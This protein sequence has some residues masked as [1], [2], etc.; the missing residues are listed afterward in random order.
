MDA[1]QRRSHWGWG[2][3]DRFPDRDTR[4]SFGAH[5]RDL[6]G[7]AAPRLDEPVPLSGI[8]LPESRGSPIEPPAPLVALVTADP[9]ARIRH[10]HGRAY[11]DVLRGLRGDFTAAPDLVATPQSEDDVGHVLEWAADLQLAVVPYGGGTSVVAGVSVTE[12]RRAEHAGV[13]SLDMTGLDRVLEVQPESLHARIQAGAAGP[14]LEE[15]LRRHGLTLRFFPQSYEHSTLGGWIATRAGGH[16]ATGSTHIDDLVAATRMLTPGGAMES[17]RLP[18]SGA[19]PSPDRLVLGSEGSLGVITEAWMRVRPRPVFRAAA[20]VEFADWTAAV[21]AVRVISQSGLQPS[22]CRL[23]D[24]REAALNAVTASGG[25]VLILG[26]ES[27]DHELRPWMRRCLELAAEHGGRTTDGPVY[28]DAG[29]SAGQQGGAGAWREAFVAAPYLMNIGASLGLIVDTFETAVPWDRFA[30]L[31]AAV[32]ADVGAAIREQCGAGSLSCRFTHV[33]PDGPA[34]YYTV[35]APGRFGDELRQWAAIKQAAG[36]ALLAHGATITH[37]H[38]VGRTH[39]PWADQQRPDV[40]TEVLRAAKA[41]L[42]PCGIM[43]PGVLF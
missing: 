21:H 27:A 3:E 40:F 24:P 43:N 1:M 10:T 34:P 26:F 33:Y 4:A 31:D 35:V 5:V 11:P 25:S 22:N 19:G 16:F 36:D 8:T 38:A 2:W 30:E 15:Q 28:R 37:H 18:A 32:R 23:L 14:V 39:R 29:A 20:T 9:Q 42:D 6:L 13:L 7:F 17:R 12:S 41:A